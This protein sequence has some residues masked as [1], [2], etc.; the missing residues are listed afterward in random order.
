M[1]VLFLKRGRSRAIQTGECYAMT[2][3]CSE[4]SSN[5]R[6]GKGGGGEAKEWNAE[7]GDFAV[8]ICK[9][10]G[11]GRVKRRKKVNVH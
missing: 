11:R 5:A 6:G 8:K 9:M 7:R 4:R 1:S 10:K 2:R 3:A